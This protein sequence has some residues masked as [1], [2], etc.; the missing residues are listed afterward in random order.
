[1][2]R[3]RGGGSDSLGEFDYGGDGGAGSGGGGGGG[4]GGGGGDSNE[5]DGGRGGGS[6]GDDTPAINNDSRG[7]GA[8]ARA[9]QYHPDV[10]SDDGVERRGTL[11]SEG[12]TRI[13]SRYSPG[14]DLLAG[15]EKQLATGESVSFQSGYAN[16]NQ[17]VSTNLI[18]R[19]HTSAVINGQVYAARDPLKFFNSI[20]KAARENLAKYLIAIGAK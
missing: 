13:Q 18:Q 4:T 8:T 12:M 15:I 19:G 3:K 1:V 14:G 7:D 10:A 20:P 11:T 9:A 17:Q 6:G 2:L 5:S 16:I